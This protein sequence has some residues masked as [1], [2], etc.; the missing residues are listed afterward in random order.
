MGVTNLIDTAFQ[1]ADAREFSASGRGQEL[2]IAAHLSMNDVARA[3]GT[4]PAAVSRWERAEHKPTGATGIRWGQ[5]C[6]S[7]ERRGS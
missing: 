5:F 4:T 3:I 2:R 6:R 7:L 1:L